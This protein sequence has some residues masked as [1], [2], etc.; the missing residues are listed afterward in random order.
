[1]VSLPRQRP[2]DR[3]FWADF[4]AEGPLAVFVRLRSN[5]VLMTTASPRAGTDRNSSGAYSRSRRQ[6]CPECRSSFRRSRSSR[7]H[8]DRA[9]VNFDARQRDQYLECL[10]SEPFDL[11][12]IGGGI[13]G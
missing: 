7:G 6:L 5:T 11:L 3:H 13:T 2:I 4:W 10:A 8:Y 1:M 9:P 12:V